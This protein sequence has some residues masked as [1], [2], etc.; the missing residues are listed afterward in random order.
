MNSD[1][2][3]NGAAQTTVECTGTAEREVQKKEER[4]SYTYE[5][6]VAKKLAS[7]GGRLDNDETYIREVKTIFEGD[8]ASASAGL[9]AYLNF[10][11]DGKPNGAYTSISSAIDGRIASVTAITTK[12][13]WGKVSTLIDM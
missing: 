2:S 13:R 7:Y 1:M 6:D 5:N 8:E 10:G 11:K 12:D 3:W 9:L 4:Q